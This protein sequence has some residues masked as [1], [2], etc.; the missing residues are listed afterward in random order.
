MK[1]N[2]KI[3]RESLP[4]QVL[5]DSV[6]IGT[7]FLGKYSLKPYLKIGEATREEEGSSI[8]EN[9]V[10][11]GSNTETVFCYDVRIYPIEIEIEVT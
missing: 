11:I 2:I 5:F 4:E 8:I 6:D 7:F 1:I 9:V 10:P 3:D